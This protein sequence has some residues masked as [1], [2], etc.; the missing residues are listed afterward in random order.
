MS[1]RSA[2]S[3]GLSQKNCLLG[4]ASEGGRADV[5]QDDKY[6]SRNESAGQGN[7]ANIC[8]AAGWPSVLACII[9][10]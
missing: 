2:C 4:I 5:D 6:E 3:P 8:S 7:C 9:S 10:L 1:A